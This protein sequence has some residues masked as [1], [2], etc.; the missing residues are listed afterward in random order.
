MHSKRFGLDSPR[1]DG[2]ASPN[3][4]PS[5]AS[6]PSPPPR[7]ASSRPARAASGHYDWFRHRLMFAILDVQGRVIGFSG[8]VLPDPETGIVDKQSPKYINSP[9]S[10]DLPKRSDPVRSLPS[11]PSDPPGGGG[12]P[13]RRQLRRRVAARARDHQRG[14]A[15]RHC[16]HRRSRANSCVATPRSSRCSSTETPRAKKPR[17]RRARRAARAAWSP[18][19]R[20][21][22]TP[23]IPTT[24]CAS[25]EPR[26]FARRV[27]ASHG[28]LEHLI[29][30]TLDEA[31]ER[32]DAHERGARVREVVQLIAS[33]DDPTVRA[34][35]QTYADNIAQRIG[36]P[37][38]ASFRPC[39]LRSHERSP[40]RQTA[41]Q[42]QPKRR[43]GSTGPRQAPA[44]EP[45]T[46]S[47]LF[48]A[49]FSISQSF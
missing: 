15:A 48:S 41:F 49:V 21:S 37:D 42:R 44:R 8:R 28:I 16:I 36:L 39:N 46:R 31:F 17:A 33:E 35:A 40:R 18:R 10:P 11:S 19:S 26:H 1:P 24:S 22:P 20:C 6:R 32:G 25:A 45:G 3:I 5:R 23:K 38:A 29:E 27:Q 9:E 12:G 43:F 2:T 47:A 13:R 30:S 7:W 34:M 4:S 14:R